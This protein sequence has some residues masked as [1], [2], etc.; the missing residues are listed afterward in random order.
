MTSEL[1]G[2]HVLALYKLLENA[3]DDELTA[4][5]NSL[6]E[7]ARKNPH[8][9]SA[10]VREFERLHS[11]AW[12]GRPIP[13][14]KRVL[15]GGHDVFPM[16]DR[17]FVIFLIVWTIMWGFIGW[18]LGRGFRKLKDKLN[19][20]R[21][22]RLDRAV[23]LNQERDR[24]L[25]LML[26][27]PDLD[28]FN[29]KDRMIIADEWLTKTTSLPKSNINI[30]MG[31]IGDREFSCAPAWHFFDRFLSEITQA[32]GISSS[33]IALNVSDRIHLWNHTG[34]RARVKA[35]LKAHTGDILT[36]CV[37]R[38]GMLASA[39]TDHT[40]CLWDTKNNDLAHT[41]EEH[42]EPVRALVELSDGRLV[43][44]AG[45]RKLLVWNTT[46]YSLIKSVRSKRRAK[47]LIV[48]LN[49]RLA[50]C[51]DHGISIWNT[52]DWMLVSEVWLP[53]VMILRSA[54]MESGNLVSLTGDNT[55]KVWNV[56]D[57]SII[58]TIPNINIMGTLCILPDNKIAIKSHDVLS[59]IDLL[60][61]ATVVRQDSWFL[62]MTIMRIVA[63]PNGN[64]AT[65][66]TEGFV[67]EWDPTSL[68]M[69]H[70]H[71]R[72]NMAVINMFVLPTEGISD[73]GLAVIYE[74]N[75]V[76]VFR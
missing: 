76:V 28:T 12:P 62:P 42:T 49:N 70:R 24:K 50:S 44:A 5:Y 11:E 32:I 10:T 16:S 1:G 51:S 68:T 17:N 47:S 29:N 45:E 13:D 30:I 71:Q 60:S 35:S 6:M 65:G 64:I 56:N 33:V 52:H 25:A 34:G 20:N 18:G 58:V 31:Y 46:T 22:A 66:S 75:H 26:P 27:V 15:R 23:Q 19:D 38:D 39:S 53:D 8:S 63:L 4:R 48:L 59:V 61:G 72:T 41:F 7:F 57:M 43:S 3:S 37:L 69:I 55:L 40:I 21:N 36:M 14:I 9:G 73:F 2:R 54:A 74:D 67:C